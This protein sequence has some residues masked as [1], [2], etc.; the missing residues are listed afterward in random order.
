MRRPGRLVPVAGRVEAQLKG[1]TARGESQTAHLAG[2]GRAVGP[3]GSRAAAGARGRVSRFPSGA[4]PA[5]LAGF[6]AITIGTA[7][8]PATLEPSEAA[9][10]GVLELGLALVDLVDEAVGQQLAPAG[11]G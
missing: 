6:P 9:M 7:P 10:R 1:E 5:R 11:R 2:P 8:S 4:L 3:G